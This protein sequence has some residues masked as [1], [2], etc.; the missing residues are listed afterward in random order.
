MNILISGIGGRMGRRCARLARSGFA[1]ATLCGGVHLS[2]HAR[3]SAEHAED[4][5]D[6]GAYVMSFSDGQAPVLCYP[7][8]TGAPREID[9][10]VDFSDRHCTRALL[11][12]ALCGHFPVV[13]ATTG[14]TEM[15]R[16][17]IAE[18]ARQIPIFF[19][20]NCSL[21]MAYF[22]D[23][24]LHA[25][26][27]FAGAQVEIVETHGARKADAPGGTAMTLARAIAARTPGADIRI[28]RSGYGARRPGEIGVHA[29][30]LGNIP[31]THEVYIGTPEETLLLRY[32]VHERA[33]Y[34]RGAL[35]AAAFLTEAVPGLYGMEDI[36]A[37]R[38]A[39]N[40]QG[41]DAG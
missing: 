2:R 27:A 11:D 41:G 32:E 24:V 36:L 19:A 39:Q 15:E 7:D 13:I 16:A 31:G 25:V 22:S 30:R 21:G 40:P 12:F 29:L 33:V 17:A 35:L 20:A 23:I 37:P 26:D 5:Q 14:Q 6:T 34:A 9:C 10:I 18:A 8:F 38:T 3:D 28:G 1:G 4:R